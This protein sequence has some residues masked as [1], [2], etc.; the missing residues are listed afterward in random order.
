MSDDAVMIV[1]S[2]DDEPLPEG[3][4]PSCKKQR[5]A[6]PDPDVV[7]E[8]RVDKPALENQEEGEEQ[9]DLIITAQS[10][11]FS[12]VHLEP[13]TPSPKPQPPTPNPQPQPLH[14]DLPHARAHCASF[15]ALVTTARIGQVEAPNQLGPPVPNQSAAFGFDA[16]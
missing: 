9:E 3:G 8:E 13:Q 5:R 2:S 15:P 6:D 10:G 1:D 7:I 4:A 12:A 16:P 14:Q 11:T